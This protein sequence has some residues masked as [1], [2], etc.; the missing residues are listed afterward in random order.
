MDLPKDFQ[1]DIGRLAG[2]FKHTVATYKFYWMLALIHE[3]EK[4]NE[5]VEK[6]SLF[7][8]MVAQS[9]Y[10]VNYFKVSFGASDLLQKAVGELQDLES[11]PVDASPAKIHKQ[12]M[13]SKKAE[14]RKILQHFDTNVPHRFLS[15]W[16][17]SGAKKGVYELSQ[18][19]L[20]HPPYALYEDHLL[21]QP[22]W[23]EYFRRYAGILRGFCLWHLTLFLQARNPNVPDIP[24]KLVRPEQRSSLTAHKKR[25]WDLVL[26]R[27]GGMNCIYTGKRLHV[28]EYDMEHF[29]PFQFVAHDQMWNLIPADPSFNSSK[30]DKLPPLDVYFQPFYRAQREAVSIVK[31]A[32]P[33]SKFLEDYL[34]LFRSHDFDAAAYRSAIEPLVAIASNNG[35]QF[36]Q[37]PTFHS[38]AS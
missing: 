35:F 14:T 9:W 3:I 6:R 1:V 34:Q 33:K 24:N 29:I 28:G 8:H 19:G 2:C 15:P 31:A 21:V 38:A 13:Q 27:Q 25:F 36:M 18:H 17:G 16:L 11:I 30:G 23:A 5:R 7:A 22:G 20:N 32:Q 37:P 26:E 4:G 12:L 10:T